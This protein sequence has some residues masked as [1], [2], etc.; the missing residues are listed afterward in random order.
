MGVDEERHGKQVGRSTR[1]K[2]TGDE[3]F[4]DR[5]RPR[6]PAGRADAA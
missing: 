1:A 4:V 2:A 6:T 5:L 3:A